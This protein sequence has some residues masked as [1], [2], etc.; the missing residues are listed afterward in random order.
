[1]AQLFLPSGQVRPNLFTREDQDAEQLMSVHATPGL[2]DVAYVIPRAVAIAS[3]RGKR[4]KREAS[5]YDSSRAIVLH[6]KPR[7]TL[8]NIYTTHLSYGQSASMLFRAVPKNLDPWL[9]RLKRAKLNSNILYSDL[10]NDLEHAF[11]PYPGRKAIG[12][13]MVFWTA[14]R[15]LV[16]RNEGSQSARNG[17]RM[18][19]YAEVGSLW[20]NVLER[21]SMNSLDTEVR[22]N[23]PAAYAAPAEV[24]WLGNTAV[25]DEKIAYR[26]FYGQPDYDQL[27]TLMALN[28]DVLFRVEA[29]K[30]LIAGTHPGRELVQKGKPIL[31]LYATVLVRLSSRFEG[32]LKDPRYPDFAALEEELHK[33]GT[34]KPASEIGLNT[35]LTLKEA[36]KYFTPGG[37]YPK[38]LMRHSIPNPNKVLAFLG[39]I[40]TTADNAGGNLAIGRNAQGFP[41]LVEDVNSQMTVVIGPTGSGKT[42]WTEVVL[43]LQRTPRVLEVKFAFKPDI[44]KGMEWFVQYGGMA[45]SPGTASSLA[46]PLPAGINLTDG[47]LLDADSTEKEI[48]ILEWT[49]RDA[50]MTAVKAVSVLKK[51]CPF[52]LFPSADTVWFYEY[53][54]WFWR[55]FVHLWKLDKSNNGN[56]VSVIFD[57]VTKIVPAQKSASLN[58]L[59]ISVGGMIRHEI[60]GSISTLRS[61]G[62]PLTL[63][64]HSLQGLLEDFP[65]GTITECQMALRFFLDGHQFANRG[66]PSSV[67][68]TKDQEFL[69]TGI[70]INLGELIHVTFGNPTP[71]SNT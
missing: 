9:S 10:M 46:T 15:Y 23:G 1:M 20:K 7:K 62:F 40:I 63:L 45:F 5:R 49:K 59:P 58:D 41:E 13:D 8:A 34:W 28:A 56:I 52:A 11:N 27:G 21:T 39:S 26:Y 17:G 14:S 71:I 50:Y 53:A 30:E 65:T 57:D 4:G 55:A 3:D 12:R 51:D 22:T 2:R 68:F 36:W 54:T 24:A 16:P 64:G 60:R 69:Q 61:M 18:I 43:G 44:D 70:Q 48:M 32:T 42:T 6:Q 29:H 37:Q 47:K 66:V 25:A 35:K 31:V 19:T 67:E 33:R 38:W